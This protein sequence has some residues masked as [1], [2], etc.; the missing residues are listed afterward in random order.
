MLK[1]DDIGSLVQ[2]IVEVGLFGLVRRLALLRLVVECVLST[3]TVSGEHAFVLIGALLISRVS[4]SLRDT[5]VVLLNL[6]STIDSDMLMQSG[7][8]ATVAQ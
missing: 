6:D 3:N 4:H 5:G 1:G 2:V 7:R 8:V